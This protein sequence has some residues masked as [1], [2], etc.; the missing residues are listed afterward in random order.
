MQLGAKSLAIPRRGLR[1]R[2][3]H[4]SHCLRSRES[5]RDIDQCCGSKGSIFTSALEMAACLAEH[6]N[7]QFPVVHGAGFGSRSEIPHGAAR[8]QIS[9]GAGAY[10]ISPAPVRQPPT[11]DGL[12][13]KAKAAYPYETRR[14]RPTRGCCPVIPCPPRKCCIALRGSRLDTCSLEGGPLADRPVDTGLKPQSGGRGSES[15]APV[16]MRSAPVQTSV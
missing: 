9:P 12:A 6:N 11:G 5:H 14:K 7:R 16:C 15:C 4:G 10:D 3:R 8:A 13:G 1:G 2:G